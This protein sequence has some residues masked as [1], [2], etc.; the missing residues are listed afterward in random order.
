MSLDTN[1]KKFNLNFFNKNLVDIKQFIFFLIIML[2]LVLADQLIK[3]EFCSIQTIFSN[4]ILNT[5]SA[6]GIF[7]EFQF[8][9]IIV[10]VVGLIMSIILLIFY[11]YFVREFG[12]FV[13]ALCIAGIMSNTIDRIFI[14]AVRDMFSF[15]TISLFGVFN[16]ADVY[17]FITGIYI[18]YRLM[19]FK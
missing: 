12:V 14:G 19:L 7:S 6:Y 17:L 18:L 9:T 4:C 13:T 2:I 8:Y 3:L 5:G 10:A 1:Q 15:S 16:L 11:S